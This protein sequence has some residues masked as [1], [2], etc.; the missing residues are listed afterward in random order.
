M[1]KTK[2]SNQQRIGFYLSSGNAKAPTKAHKTDACYDLYATKSFRISDAQL[3]VHTNVHLDLPAGWVGL[4]F[5]RSS[6]FKTRNRLSN[7]V[8]V[9]DAGYTGQ[10]KFIFDIDPRLGKQ[11]YQAGNRVGQLLLKKLDPSYLVQMSTPPTGERGD[12]GFGST[13]Q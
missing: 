6:V 7:C 4:I 12:N 2:R 8:G 11:V 5:P 1:F 3:E 13:G 10:I 9:I